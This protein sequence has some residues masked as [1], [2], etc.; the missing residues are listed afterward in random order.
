MWPATSSTTYQC[1]SGFVQHTTSN[2]NS[3]TCSSDDLVVIRPPCL[4]SRCSNFTDHVNAGMSH[5][6]V[7]DVTDTA[8]SFACDNGMHFANHNIS[9]IS[10]LCTGSVESGGS[11]WFPKVASL[12]CIPIPQSLPETHTRRLLAV[13]AAGSVNT[14]GFVGTGGTLSFHRTLNDVPIPTTGF[15]DPYTAKMSSLAHGDRMTWRYNNFTKGGLAMSF[16]DLQWRISAVVNWPYD[17]SLS[18]PA[19]AGITE[20][21][22][23]EQPY[24]ASAVLLGVDS[25]GYIEGIQANVTLSIRKWNPDSTMLRINETDGK[26][27]LIKAYVPETGDYYCLRAFPQYQGDS[28]TS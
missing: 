6:P 1:L 9:E 19:L 7:Y 23:D 24:N 25:I 5:G 17:S 27:F 21:P 4:P 28:W 15:A 18:V 13:A 2:A 3:I 22:S 14:E 10:V 8:T 11:D 26:L 20:T 16:H 12:S